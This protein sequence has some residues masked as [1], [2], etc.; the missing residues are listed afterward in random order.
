M[1]NLAESPGE[2]PGFGPLDASTSRALADEAA[3]DPATRW[4]LTVTDDLGHVIGHGCQHRQRAG[5]LPGGTALRVKP[6][7]A[8]EPTKP[9]RP[10]GEHADLVI[11]LDPLAF[12]GCD[13]RLETGAY[14]PSPKLRHLIEIR[15]RCC[16]FPGCRRPPTRCDKDHTIPYDRGGR[17][18]LCNLAPLCRTH[19]QV[20]Q[21]LGWQLHQP[22]PGVFEWITPCGRKYIIDP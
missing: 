20:K 17:T 22:F 5:P 2:V 1:L 16:S 13:H 7:Q 11:K 15:D 19:H 14:K 12:S 3:S 8:A 18:C 9:G 6:A 10:P 4:C 21:A